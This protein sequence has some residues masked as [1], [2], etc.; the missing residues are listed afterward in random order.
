MGWNSW[1]SYGLT[2]NETQFKQNVEWFNSHLKRYGWQYVVIDEGWYLE[3]PEN[4]AT[5]GADQGYR[6]DANG[7]Y[8]PATNRFPTAASAAGFKQLADYVHGLGLKFG[9]HIIRGIPRQAVERNLPIAHSSFHAK[10]AADTNDTCQ[11]NSDNYGIRD[12]AAG[13][14]YYNSIARLY[15]RWGVDFVKIDCISHP[16]RK[17][18][19]RMV[20]R[21]LKATSR[22][23]VLSL[24]PGPTPLEEAD[25]VMT[26]AQMWRISDDFWDVWQ[27]NAGSN[28]AFP[29]S[30]FRQFTLLAKWEQYAG[31]GHWPDADMLPFGTLGPTPG[32]QQPRKSR[33]TPDEMRTVFTLWSIARSP[34]VLG[35][36]LTQM[37]S[38]TESLITNADLIAVDQH[39]TGNKPL[40]DNAERAVWT[41]RATSVQGRYVAVFNKS[42][43]QLS[44]KY[45]WQELGIDNGNHAARDLATHA[46]L[47]SSAG[48]ETALP[49]HASVI[50]RVQ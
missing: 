17:S 26:Q 42:D 14:A 21:S 5:K 6:M 22:S 33:F 30:A 34:L 41:A 16:Y 19:I 50:Y 23:I 38:A 39:S 10:D 2:I 1:D 3:H 8:V 25:D 47:Q 28:D 32:W 43:H 36:N 29:Q 4:A 11:W 13:Q 40:I 48:I 7:R 44:V 20:S 31:P 46:D 35:T 27:R 9:I 15:A 49:P 45:S 37:D 12:N 18:E 24:S